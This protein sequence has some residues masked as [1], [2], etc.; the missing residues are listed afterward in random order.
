MEGEMDSKILQG[1]L[2]SQCWK[3]TSVGKGLQWKDRSGPV[4]SI[5]CRC[6]EHGASPRVSPKISR[7]LLGRLCHVQV[8][9][10]GIPLCLSFPALKY[11]QLIYYHTCCPQGV[12]QNDLSLTQHYYHSLP[13]S[14]K[15]YS[16]PAFFPSE[17]KG[18][19][20]AEFNHWASLAL[21]C[22]G[23]E[24]QSLAV[25]ELHKKL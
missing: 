11:I 23:I 16:L 7:L 2:V 19:E 5:V 4:C 9:L 25:R 15:S 14:F 8:T 12:F 10:C 13:S 3:S 6:F 22:Y 20:E 1:Y 24:P 18:V 17:F 21:L